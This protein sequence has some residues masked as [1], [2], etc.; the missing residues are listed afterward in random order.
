VNCLSVEVGKYGRII[1]PK[2]VREK[3][4]VHEGVRL[5]VTEYRGSICLVPV[6]VYGKPT[7]ALFGAVKSREPVE[8]P[9]R[10]ARAYVR[11]KLVEDLR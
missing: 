10:M 4:G 5:V 2:R 11:K 7:E 6:R 1:L 3:Y 9:K 8:E